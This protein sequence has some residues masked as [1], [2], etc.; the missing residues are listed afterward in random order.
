IVFEP[1]EMDFA[2]IFAAIRLSRSFV[3]SYSLQTDIQRVLL[4]SL[5]IDAKVRSRIRIADPTIKSL[6]K[7]C[8]STEVVWR[9]EDVP[10]GCG[11]AVLS[12]TLTVYILVRVCVV[13]LNPEISKCDEK[14]SLA[15]CNADELRKIEA[16]S[17]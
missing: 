12:N 13:D 11:S 4:R 7:G 5:G 6:N 16:Q 8:N 17:D 14:L 2:T 15:T 3:V 1:A 9:I 10:A